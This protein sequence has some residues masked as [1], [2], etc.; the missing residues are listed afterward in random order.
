MDLS[1]FKIVLIKNKLDIYIKVS[2]RLNLVRKNIKLC[3]VLF[4]LA[5]L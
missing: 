4:D 5:N 3:Q 1:K 2:T